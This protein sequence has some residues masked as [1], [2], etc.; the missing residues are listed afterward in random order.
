[1]YREKSTTRQGLILSFPTEFF[2]P[3]SKTHS[4]VAV[5]FV[6][7]VKRVTQPSCRIDD[8]LHM[9]LKNFKTWKINYHVGNNL[10]FGLRIQLEL[11]LKMKKIE[12]RR[13]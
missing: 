2:F 11:M 10:S 9:Q 4:R 3:K 7:K 1:M 6:S 8:D 12:N 13:N 5:L